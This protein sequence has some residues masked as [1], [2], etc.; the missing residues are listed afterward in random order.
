MSSDNYLR[1][2]ECLEQPSLT[3]WQLCEEVDVL[4]LPSTSPGGHPMPQTVTLATPTQTSSTLDGASAA[5]AAHVAAQQQQTQMPNRPGLG[6][7]EVREK[8][9]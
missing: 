9:V 3:T 8:D 2:Y 1:V 7:R 4:S 6:T 5:L